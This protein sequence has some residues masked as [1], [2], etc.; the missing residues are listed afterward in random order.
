[1]AEANLSEQFQANITQ[2]LSLLNIKATVVVDE[3]ELEGK[4][5]FDVKIDAAD[6]GSELIGHHGSTLDSLSVVLSLLL[7]STEE[8]YSILLDVNGYRDERTKYIEDLTM[9]AV[10]QVVNNQQS[11]V[12][13]PMKPW[14]RRIVHMAVAER[15][16]I[17]TESQGEEPDRRVVIKP[18][19]AGEPAA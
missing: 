11:I 8:R 1:M 19:N 12:L 17:L 13:Q 10:D 7:P 16:D 4:K 9:K 14:E 2:L 18:A 3:S 6:N 5:Y 15:T